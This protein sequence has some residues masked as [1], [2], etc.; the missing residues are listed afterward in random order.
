METPTPFDLN[1]AIRRWQQDLGA[2][3]AFCADNLEELASHLRASVL[4]LKAGG[5]SEEEAFLI[6]AQRLGKPGQLEQE[7]AKV[8]SFATRSWTVILFW[9]VTCIYLFQ[10]VYSLIAGL[11]VWRSMSEMREMQGELSQLL[12]QG[13]P[14]GQIYRI[15]DAHS[16]PPVFSV[17]TLSIVALLVF[18]LGARLVAGSWQRFSAIIKIFERPTHAVLVTLG[19]VVLGH[20]ATLSPAY[21]SGF[22]E[23]WAWN[24]LTGLPVVNDALVLSMA[25]LARRGKRLIPCRW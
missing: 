21:V 1:T 20:V 24:Y 10:V 22:H 13:A 19:L 3:P 8:N 15:F 5:L 25:L 4:K 11:R 16:Y 6:A 14:L 12:S 18:I 9:L 7:F 23:D 17:L 2:S